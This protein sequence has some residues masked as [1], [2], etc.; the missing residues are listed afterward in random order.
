MSS[1]CCENK[2]HELDQLRGKQAKVLKLVFA[3]NFAMFF[4]EFFQ[5]WMARSTA[6]MAD[7]LDMLGDAFVYGFSLYVLAK[8]D[9]WKARA[10]TLKGVI[11]LG[12]GLFVLAEAI[13]KILHPVL[14]QSETMGMIGL[15]ALVANLVCLWLLYAHRQ[16]DINMQSTWLC[17]RNDIIANSSTL[18]AAYLVTKLNSWWPDII[19]GTLIA[20]LFLKTSIGV[21]RSAYHATR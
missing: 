1:S 16:D 7:S 8:S 13:H 4:I 15:L 9:L 10:A 2:S 17:S 19:V 6:L 12:F 21:L 3:I 14:P 11:M 18:V 5:G 20:S